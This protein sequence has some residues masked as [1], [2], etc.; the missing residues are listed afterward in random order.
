MIQTTA[1][2]LDCYDACKIVFEETKPKGDPNHPAGNGALCAVVNRYM[3]KTKRITT[4]RIDGNEVTLDEALIATAEAFKVDKSLLW[5]GSGNVGVMQEITNLF[6]EK[7]DGYLT[8]G[9]LCDGAGAAGIEAGRGV[10]RTLPLEQIAKAQTVVVWGRNI[11]VTNSHLMPLLEGKKLIVIDPIKTAIAKQATIHLQI[12]PRTDYYVAILLSRFI[13]MEDS[14]N[15]AWLEEFAP[16]F[17]DY[18]DYTKEHRIKAILQHLNLNLGDFGR[19]LHHLKEHKVVFLV[20]TGVQKYSIGSYALRAID[21]LAAILGLFG[22]EGCGVS[23]L[24][25][26]KLGFENPFEV[27]CKRVSKVATPFSKFGTVL[28]QGGNPCESMPDTNRTKKELLEVENLIYF[29]LYENETSKM[30]RIVIP[31]KHFYEK[32][33]VRLSYGHHFVTSMH[34]I[35]ESSIGVLAELKI[36]PNEQSP[37]GYANAKLFSADSSRTSYLDFL[38]CKK[39]IGISEYDFT[40]F[41]FEHF[42]LDG[43]QSESYYLDAW[44]SQCKTNQ[45]EYISPAYQSLPYSDGFGENGK[46]MFAFVDEFNDEFINT[47]RFTKYR[48]QSQNKLKDETLWLITPKSNHSINT[49]FKRD[50]RVILHP[51]IGF[52]EGE[53]VKVE[54][55]HGEFIFEVL[56]SQDVREDCAVIFSNAFGV[57]YLTPSLVSDEGESACYQEVKVTVE[58]I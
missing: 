51:N 35:Q 29:G 45:K 55:D 58:R 31:A 12:P 18:Y 9:T 48:K 22:R 11:T 36:T 2:A 17:Q 23:Y 30:A 10:N 54:S 50:N 44:L 4:P 1:C 8:K 28:I 32:E 15:K 6:I 39:S 3:P 38:F 46:E 41:L 40:H 56:C 49:Q 24:G 20:G 34:K 14:E 52:I 16:D 5:R 53:K 7:I 33:D 57:N 43:L 21:S 19:V 26:S 37:L 27:S 25:N 47:K 13:F 42:G